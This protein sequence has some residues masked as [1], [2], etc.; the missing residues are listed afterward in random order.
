M[1]NNPFNSFHDTVAEAKKEREQLDRLLTVSTPRERLIVVTI[2][3][4][5]IVFSAWLFLGNVT[6]SLAVDGVFVGSGEHSSGD[7]Q[8]VQVIVWIKGD[9]ARDIQTKMPVVIELGTTDGEIEKLDGKI[10]KISSEPLS[11]GL[12][13]FES[14]APVSVHRVEVLLDEFLDLSS[15]TDSKCQ[16]VIQI[17]SQPPIALFRM[18]SS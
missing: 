8:A 1:F 18:K 12:A 16:I 10:A 7:S 13:M 14:E 15:Y 9:A 4:I 11:E 17:G 3:L 2:A 5:L 6:R